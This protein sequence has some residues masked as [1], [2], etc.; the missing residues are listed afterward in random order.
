MI[1][2]F[3]RI[4]AFGAGMHG[5]HRGEPGTPRGK[6]NGGSESEEEGSRVVYIVKG[7]EGVIGDNIQ[8]IGH[9]IIVRGWGGFL[10]SNT[11]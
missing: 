8:S 10:R 5:V 2:P 4:G 6:P 9:R 7:M 11:S 1:I 3:R